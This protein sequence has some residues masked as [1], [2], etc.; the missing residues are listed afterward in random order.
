VEIVLQEDN[1]R[2]LG[3]V[4]GNLTDSILRFYVELFHIERKKSTHV[5]S[6]P[7]SQVSGTSTPTMLILAFWT[8]STRKRRRRMLRI[9]R[10]PPRR[11]SWR[12]SSSRLR[13]T[14]NLVDASRRK[15]ISD[16]K[17]PRLA[18]RDTTWRQSVS[19]VAGGCGQ[20]IIDFEDESWL[21]SD[22]A[23]RRPG[24]QRMF[25]LGKVK[26]DTNHQGP[27]AEE[28]RYVVDLRRSS[29]ID[30]GIYFGT[31]IICGCCSAGLLTCGL[32]NSSCRGSPTSG[33]RVLSTKSRRLHGANCVTNTPL[34]PTESE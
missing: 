14:T 27:P 22:M 32:C 26:W 12:E 21:V 2:G 4:D 24:A 15:K 1:R 29:K 28:T 18:P 19:D 30:K 23:L 20:A 9:M 16:R 10:A 7:P 6:L 25:G 33:D 13:P 11:A 5:A 17:Y 34:L 31:R 8:L 3:V